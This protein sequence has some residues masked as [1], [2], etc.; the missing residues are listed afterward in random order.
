MGLSSGVWGKENRKDTRGGAKRLGLHRTVS[1]SVA[2]RTRR[3]LFRA[4][5]VK[6]K[7]VGQRPTKKAKL[8]SLQASKLPELG[9]WRVGRISIQ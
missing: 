4:L 7:G 1:G 5:S 8:P 2:D 6:S 3:L 9:Q